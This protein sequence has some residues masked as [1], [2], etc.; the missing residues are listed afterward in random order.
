YRFERGVDP[1]F[2]LPG[3]DLA[4]AT[5]LEVAG[6]KPSKAEVA[7]APPA[8]KT[9]IPFSF[10][11]VEK[12]AGIKLP[13]K[14]MRAT[15]EALGFAIDGKGATVKVK[16]PS[17]R[18]DIHGAADVVEEIVRIVGLDKVPSAPMP[19]TSGVAK[20]VLTETQKRVRHARRV[21]A[22]RR[23]VEAI[24]WSF[25]PRVQAEAF[26]GGQAGLELAN[27]ISA[28]MTTMRPSLLAGLLAAV[29]RNR[30]RGAADVGLFEI[31]QAYR[32]DGPKDQLIIAA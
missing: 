21:L 20:P 31:G 24:T 28:E 14:E 8:A 25:I 15:L 2:I 29:Q 4:T 22:G 17:W 12:L 11:M 13:D 3:L 19:R 30:N 1:G 5:M 18:P 32:G 10:G 26:G 23:L 6:G 16:A 7:G 9:V 27:P